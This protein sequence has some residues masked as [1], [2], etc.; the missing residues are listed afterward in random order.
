[1]WPFDEALLSA[2]EESYAYTGDLL[3]MFE[4]LVELYQE[5]Y[6][7]FPR[8]GDDV[9][10]P[11]RAARHIQLAL[12][13]LNKTRNRPKTPLDALRAT[14]SS[15]YGPREIEE[16]Q[17]V[18][19]SVGIGGGAAEPDSAD[20]KTREPST[21][22]TP[23]GRKG[24]VG[25][26]QKPAPAASSRPAT[27]RAPPQVPPTPPVNGTTASTPSPGSGGGESEPTAPVP[28]SG[29][30]RHDMPRK[31]PINNEKGDARP[32]SGTEAKRQNGDR[33]GGERVRGR[34]RV[35]GSPQ[36]AAPPIAPSA[37][38]GLHDKLTALER[39]LER[40][41]RANASSPGGPSAAGSAPHA[42]LEQVV[43]QTTQLRQEQGALRTGLASLREKIAQLEG[44]LKDAASRKQE[45]EVE[46]GPRTRRELEALKGGLEALESE[47]V[48]IKQRLADIEAWLDTMK[49]VVASLANQV[50]QLE[51]VIGA[52]EPTPAPP[53]KLLGLLTRKKS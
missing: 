22:P 8:Q 23:A 9:L 38:K 33:S 27:K 48:E 18:L 19:N 44:A 4:S 24:E 17:E 28:E 36:Q 40:Q 13:E 3:R 21:T 51:G 37:L 26:A 41:E 12:G 25:A 34:P 29:S 20:E 6:Y 35:S 47:Q 52:S 15:V 42:R 53:A 31:S 7:G 11:E 30:T 49:S 16:I 10:V 43:H 2:Q 32:K 1:M 39:R 45:L 46:P 5:H 50:S 14:E